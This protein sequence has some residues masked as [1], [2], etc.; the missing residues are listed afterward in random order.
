MKTISG[1]IPVLPIPFFEDESLDEASLRNTADWVASQG[2]SG[3]C[4]PAY[5]SEFYKL[6]EAERE[7]VISIAIDCDL[8]P[9]NAQK[10]RRRVFWRQVMV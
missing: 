1:I 8:A 2:L 9:R 6:S 7:Q 3:M 5:G 10:A 4:L